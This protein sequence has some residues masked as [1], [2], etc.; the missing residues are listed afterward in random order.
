MAGLQGGMKRN[1]PLNPALFAWIQKARIGG[2]A[3]KPHLTLRKQ[4]KLPL[5]A[6]RA[7]P[8]KASLFAAVN[9]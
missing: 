1:A 9:I 6:M 2:F 8:D 3:Y 7:A 5:S 4:D